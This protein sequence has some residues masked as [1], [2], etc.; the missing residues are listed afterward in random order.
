MKATRVSDVGTLLDPI[1]KGWQAIDREVVDLAGMPLH[2]QTSR[3]VRT[4]WA[5]KLVGKVRAL[6]AR[7]AH[8]GERIAFHVE[9]HDDTKSAEFGERL[10]P[11]AAAVLFPCNGNAPITTLGTP[12]AGVNEWFWRADLER[13][14]NLVAHGLGTD[15]PADGAAIDG[16]A[17]W[18]DSRWSL[19]LSRPLKSKGADNVKFALG[20]KTSV[21][22]TVWEGSNRE[23]GDLRSYSREWRELTLEP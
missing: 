7:A 11:D 12:D 20:R 6:S 5:D 2:V 13:P 18:G 15:T 9:W 21:G 4:I 10:F 8:D 1:A 17:V 22:F 19:V 23:R 16:G 14:E 3:Y